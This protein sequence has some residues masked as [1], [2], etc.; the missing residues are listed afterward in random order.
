MQCHDR[1]SLLFGTARHHVDRV[2]FGGAMEYPDKVRGK[3]SAYSKELIA[4][5]LQGRTKKKWR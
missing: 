4:A 2:K 5:F 1:A 3:N